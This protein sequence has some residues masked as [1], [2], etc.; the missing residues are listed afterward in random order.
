MN[1]RHRTVHPAVGYAVTAISLAAMVCYSLWSWD[2]M[3]AQILT[4]QA[5]GRHGASVVSRAVAAAAMPVALA[6]SALLLLLMPVWNRLTR[7]LAPRTVAG[8]RHER[9]VWTVVL[10]MLSALMLALH[11]GIVDMY[12][13]RG[14]QLPQLA[15]WAMAALL[16]GLAVIYQVQRVRARRAITGVLVTGGALVAALAHPLPVAALIVGAVVML[17]AI[18]AV[19]AAQVRDSGLLG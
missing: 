1:T 9:L 6:A 8:R 10:V 3:P 5:A 2:D 7:P 4:R 11:V 12:T 18:V 17:G 14:P 19:A 13:G 15:A 16:I